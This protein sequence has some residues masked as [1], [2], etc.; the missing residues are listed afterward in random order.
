MNVGGGAR[1]LQA[2]RHVNCG[3]QGK[4]LSSLTSLQTDVGGDKLQ[5]KLLPGGA[6]MSHPSSLPA[7]RYERT[8]ARVREKP[9]L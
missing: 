2:L 9:G 1:A 3:V 5:M 7:L 8:R 4:L 6:C